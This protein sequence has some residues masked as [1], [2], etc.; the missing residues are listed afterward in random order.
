MESKPVKIYSTDNVPRL[1]YIAGIILED[2][3]GLSWEVISDKRR[4]GKN[5]I[6]NYSSE[7]LEGA[8][9]IDPHPLLFEQGITKQAISVTEWKDL[10]V[11]FQTQPDSDLPFDIFAA[12]FFLISRYEEYLDFEADEHG[13]FKAS[14]SLAFQNGFLGKPVIDHWTKELAITLLKKF[15]T[16]TFKSNEFRSLLTIDTDQPFAFRGKTL[17]R[18]IGGFFRDITN[19]EKNV[20]ERYRIIA[21]EEKDPF[22]VFD[23]IFE[24]IEKC[25]T[26]TLFFFPVGDHSDYD[27][28]PSWKNDEYRKLIT[29][30]AD[31]FET[32]LHPS[33][34][35]AE[36]V[37]L[38][39]NEMARL[40][41]ILHKDIA[42]SRFHYL[43]FFMP[44]SYRYL[45]E[46]DVKE[47]YSMGYADEPGFR[48][49]IAR[50]FYFYDL[51]EDKQT[52]L[53]ITPF[54]L[55]DATLYQYKNLD[56][57]IAMEVVMNLIS[58]TRK[59]RG[60]F[61]SIWHNTSLLDN[62]DCKGWREVF[63]FMLKNQVP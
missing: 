46:T 32:G 61:V 45:T 15:P 40:K 44:Q 3:L 41:T 23:Y 34:Y 56:P 2:I 55:M 21:G 18:S 36:K 31:K 13:R 54:Q 16:L 14:S 49:G 63:E 51:S 38:I 17:I 11:F 58:E 27:K 7:K 25:K 43:R 60:L 22:D 12:S 57:G 9:K 47:D 62:I 8:F 42:K 26:K 20:G 5:Y 39:D 28:N 19:N 4:L 53:K 52:I 48:A 1:N 24:N 59:A 35:S 10:P 33:Y 50:P 30:V 6:I 37:N 29:R